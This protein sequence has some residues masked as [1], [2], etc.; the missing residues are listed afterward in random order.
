MDGLTLEQ[1]TDDPGAARDDLGMRGQQLPA[2]MPQGR[3]D[4][5]ADEATVNHLGHEHVGAARQVTAAAQW[6]WPRDPWI[7]HSVEW[8]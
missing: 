5:F 6:P 1:A 7:P 8:L 3:H 4:P 2:G